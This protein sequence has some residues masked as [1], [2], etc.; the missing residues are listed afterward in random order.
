MKLHDR[1]HQ[2]TYRC[3]V[4]LGVLYLQACEGLD[5]GRLQIYIDS[6][7]SKLIGKHV[8]VKQ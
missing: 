4:L 8:P 5:M 7:G 6:C 1:V 3:V 2:D